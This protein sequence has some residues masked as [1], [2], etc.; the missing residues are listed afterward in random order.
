MAG[1]HIAL[2]TIFVSQTWEESIFPIWRNIRSE[3]F[4]RNCFIK[5]EK[6]IREIWVF[7]YKYAF[8]LLHHFVFLRFSIA[9]RLM[10]LL[11]KNSLKRHF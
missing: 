6:K 5:N 11:F 10:I 7:V 9:F 3:H 2:L 4:T 8:I 1:P